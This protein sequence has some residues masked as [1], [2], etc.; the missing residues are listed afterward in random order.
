MVFFTFTVFTV[1]AYVTRVTECILSPPG[2]ILGMC[3]IG[4]TPGI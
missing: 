1:Y 3:P 2:N 4:Y